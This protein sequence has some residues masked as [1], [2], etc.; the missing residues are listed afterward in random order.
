M[1]FLSKT[2]LTSD[3]SKSNAPSLKRLSLNIF[4]NLLEDNNDKGTFYTPKEIVHY[5][6]QESLIEYLNTHL[7]DITKVQIENLVKNQVLDNVSR[8]ELQAIEGL[9]DKIKICSM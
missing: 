5:M 7:N 8:E 9:I 1:S 4:E 6:T 2:N 3:L